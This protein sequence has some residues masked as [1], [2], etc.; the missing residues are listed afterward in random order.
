[1][2]RW[3]DLGHKAEWAATFDENKKE[4]EKWLLGSVC[5]KMKRNRKNCFSIFGG[6]FE[7]IQKDI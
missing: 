6:W 4:K 1:V 7:W 5:R 2:P 3:A